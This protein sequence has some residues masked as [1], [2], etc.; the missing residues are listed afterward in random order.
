MTSQIELEVKGNLREY[1]LAELLIEIFQAR[2]SGSLKVSNQ[3]RKAVVYVDAGDVVFAVS[4]ARE[5]RLFELLLREN[6]ISK[7]RLAAI[8][9]F[10]NDIAL[11]ERLAKNN[12]LPKTDIDRAF[13]GQIKEIL[14]DALDW[15]EGEWIFSPLVRVKGDIRFKID[16]VSLLLEHARRSP[17]S[18]IARSFKSLEEVFG[19]KSTMPE[20]VNLLP[21]EAFV[22]SRFENASLDAAKIMFLSGLPEAETLRVVYALWLGGFLTRRNWNAPFSDRMI[23]IILSANLTLKKDESAPSAKIADERRVASEHYQSPPIENAARAEVSRPVEKETSL[24]EYLER[25]ETAP[26]YYQIFDVATDASVAEIKRGYFMLAKRFHPD[27]FH[28]ETDQAKHRRIQNAF[29]KLAH[30]YET[31]KNE[32]TRTVYDYKMRKEMAETGNLPSVDEQ[33]MSGGDAKQI[34]QAKID[35][36]RGFPLLMSGNAEEAIQF[37]ARAAHLAPENA[38]YRA[39]YGKALA[40]DGKQKHK[41]E[42]ELQAA[43]RL[44]P[45]SADIRLMLV[46]FFVQM[47]LFKRA[48]GE[49]KR[50]LDSS[51]GNSEAKALLDSLPKR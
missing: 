4:N 50:L 6:K 20:S 47:K 29:T 18:E 15:R 28:T 41:A 23:S 16:T 1:R 11:K 26:S 14:L 43:L 34:E 44:A 5:F 32:S 36:E 22:Y 49:L 31:L 12:L 37:L 25:A 30:A 33:Q 38:V 39:C 42:A 2:L 13:S 8:P 40:T 10:T 7:E 9:D 3:A 46:D 48:E 19:V 24:E 35:Y 21:Q 27:L 17:A 45:E 51:P